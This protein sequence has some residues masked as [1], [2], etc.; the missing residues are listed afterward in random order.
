MISADLQA[1]FAKKIK[2]KT[3]TLKASHV[4]MISQPRQVADFVA[5]AARNVKLAK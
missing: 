3:L 1:V 2:A 5:E 4:P